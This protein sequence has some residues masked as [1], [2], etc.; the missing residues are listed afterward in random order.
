VEADGRA[1]EAD[2]V[3]DGAADIDAGAEDGPPELLADA[4]ATAD[5]TAEGGADAG[6]LVV[7][8][9]VLVHA[10]TKAVTTAA[11]HRLR[12]DRLPGRGWD[13]DRSG[14]GVGRMAYLPGARV[15]NA[16][17]GSPRSQKAGRKRPPESWRRPTTNR[18][19]AEWTVGG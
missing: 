2:A 11:M 18:R 9:P 12:S 6:G 13:S 7:A 10:A 8:L 1:P 16:T 4:L 15:W 14:A 5:G 17:T 3:A 19:T